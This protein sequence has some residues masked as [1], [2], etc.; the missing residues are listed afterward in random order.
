MHP[1]FK[2]LS[3]VLAL[4]LLIAGAGCGE[5]SAGPPAE[6]PKVTVQHPEVR[7]IRDYDEY[8]G[9]LDPA[10]TVEV[11]ARVRGHIHKVLFKDGAVVP[12]DAPLFELD[13]RPFEVEIAQAQEKL[14]VFEA[15]KEAADK[16]EARLR[17][18][19]SKGGASKRQVEKAEA[20]VKSFDAQIAATKEEV[21]RRKL[22]LEDY[23]RIRAPIA[24]RTSRALLTVGN[25]VNAGGSDPVL[26]TIV[27]IDPIYVYFYIDERSLQRYQKSR[28]DKEKG[29]KAPESVRAMKLPFSFRL[30]TEQGF[31]HEGVLNFADNKVDPNTGTILVRGRV[32]NKDDKLT[33]GS[34][35]RVRIA[36]TDEYKATLVPDTA[37]L[38]DQDKRYVLVVDDKNIV[39]RRNVTLGRLLEKDGMRVILGGGGSG[40]GLA[41]TDQVIVDGLQRARINYPVTPA[42]PGDKAKG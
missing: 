2:R 22:D 28:Q 41:P 11:R 24:G 39:H 34:R 19:L 33:P 30:D 26:T 27:S 1:L 14:K 40:E 13:P 8:N 5:H 20:D 3:L 15:Q 9:W 36:V 21:K 16:E 31:P 7:A 37:I 35:V 32:D 17:E 12:K 38:S 42:G 4:G 25:L 29:G 23:A 18:L 6:A 10:E